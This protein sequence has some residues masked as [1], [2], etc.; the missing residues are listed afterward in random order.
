MPSPLETAATLGDYSGT[1][2]G[3]KDPPASS[4]VTVHAK[5][6]EER[7]AYTADEVRRRTGAA[8]EPSAPSIGGSGPGAFPGM[9]QPPPPPKQQDT[10]PVDAWGSMAMLA[11][12]LGGAKSR[13]HA[14]AAL[15]AAAGVLQGIHKHDQEEFKKKFEEWR[16]A[17][18][19][20]NRIQ[21]YEIEAYRAAL[22][23]TGMD[24]NNFYKMSTLEQRNA[25]A[26]LRAQAIAMQNDRLKQ[27]I[28]HQRWDEIFREQ[29]ARER[30][31]ENSQ[32]EYDRLHDTGK[33]IQEY[34]NTFYVGG[35]LKDPSTQP[36]PYEQWLRE[37]HPDTARALG[38]KDPTA[39]SASAA[40]PSPAAPNER[41]FKDKDGNT[42]RYKGTGDYDDRK[43]W[44]I[45]S[46]TGQ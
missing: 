18:D 7:T 14:T 15:N 35:V 28:D 22:Q 41:T 9:V 11:A 12:A 4:D 19:N 31:A 21:N 44:E 23:R 26:D 10:S 25:A 27:Q 5:P 32:K 36:P 38:F 29:Q 17:A 1:P 8:R 43:N 46:P 20:A 30:A 6:R 16:V 45:V 24:L 39:P 34:N 2:W 40:A 33:A 37:H 42:L 3:L 13:F